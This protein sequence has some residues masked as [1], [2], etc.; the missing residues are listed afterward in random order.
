MQNLREGHS[1]EGVA[2][3]EE[4]TRG[5]RGEGRSARCRHSD[6]RELGSS[7]EHD[8]AQRHRLCQRQ[9]RP[10]SDRAEGGAESHRVKA[11]ADCGLQD[12]ATLGQ[13]LFHGPP[14]RELALRRMRC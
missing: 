8:Q 1:V 7:G 3:S 10:N 9:S 11:D 12:P 4:Q 14:S 5:H 13:R 6:E 2:N